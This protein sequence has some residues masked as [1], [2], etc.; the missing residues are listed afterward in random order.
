MIRPHQGHES[1]SLAPPRSRVLVLLASRDG[2]RWIRQQLETVLAQEDVEVR[3]VVRDDGSTDT[4]L[5]EIAA[6]SPDGRVCLSCSSDGGGSAAQNFLT[7]ILENPAEGFDYVAFS[8]QDDIWRPDKLARACRMLSGERSAGYSSATIALWPDG[9]TAP[10]QQADATTSA[11]FLFE[12]AGQGCTFVLHADFYGRIRRFVS[13]HRPVTRR[14]HYHDWMVYA[15]ARSWGER[16][17]FD[18]RPSVSY[19]QHD[20]N[21][22]GARASVAGARKRLALIRSG[23]YRKQLEAIAAVCAAAAPASSLIARWRSLLT[24]RR[25]WRRRL[26]IA[27]FCLHGGRRK[28]LDTVVLVCSA[29]AGWI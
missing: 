25:D 15:L 7:L 3:I 20:E 14:I 17:I 5:L 12:G 4:T 26:R 16:W 24:G 1:S 9:S 13:E 28:K 22:T 23:W 11:D 29:I 2:A 27:S 18:S 19:R 6:F 10:L 8:D 21:D